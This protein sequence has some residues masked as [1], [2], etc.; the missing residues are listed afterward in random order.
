MELCR[1]CGEQRKFIKAHA[2]PEAFFRELRI[3][4]E[5]P[6]LVSGSADKPPKKKSPIGVY[7]RQI[8]CET[9]EPKFGAVD[10]YGAEVLLRRFD[11]Y[12]EPCTFEGMTVGFESVRVDANRLL[13]FFVATLWRASV[14]SQPFYACV[15]LGPHQD[16]AKQFA[17]D[18]RSR[19][20]EVFDAVLSRWQETEEE[21]L[22]VTAMLDPRPERW[23]G[24][25]AYRLYLGKTIAY[26]KV[27]KRPFPNKLLV[28]SLRTAPS[29]RIVC[30]D[31]AKA[32]DLGA[33]RNTAR[34]ANENLEKMRA[35]YGRPRGAV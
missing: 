25:N 24:I 12:F 30:R 10:G 28:N 35:A 29:V 8:L 20:P 18:D 9:C 31:I 32:K 27:D 14:S 17:V 26:V 21:V 3:A 16:V 15:N 1:L 22:P 33:L 34:A 5:P 7:D 23:S 2:I 6:L 11:E 13:Q 19:A 4:D